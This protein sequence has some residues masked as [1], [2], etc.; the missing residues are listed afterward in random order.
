MNKKTFLEKLRKKLK[1]LKAD[2]IED[3]IEEYDGY[4][5]EKVLSGKTEEEAIKAFGD[6]DELVKEILC[7]YKINEDYEK[8]IKEKNALEDSIEDVVNFIKDFIKQISRK[9]KKDVI[10]FIIE[11]IALIFFIAIL[12]APVIIIEK[13]GCL[14]LE[15]LISPFGSVLAIIWKYMIEII[16]LILSIVGIVNFVKKRYFNE[17]EVSYPCNKENKKIKIKVGKEKQPSKD[18]KK[19][20]SFGKI[21]ITI[22]KVSLV[23]IVIPAVFSLLLSFSFLIVGIILLLQG[24]PYVGI[25]MCGLTYVSLNYIFLDISFRFIFNIKLNSKLLLRSIITT[26]V[27]FIIGIGLSFYEIINTTYVDG[28]PNEYKKIVKKKEE[29]YTEDTKLTC[30]SIY[31]TSCH[32]KIDDSMQDNI[33]ATITYYDFNKDYKFNDDLEYK[34]KENNEYSFKKGYDLIISDLRKRKFHDYSKLNDINLTIKLSSE[35]MQK[36]KERQDKEYSYDD[37]DENAYNKS[38]EFKDG[39][40]VYID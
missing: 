8:E 21:I 26:I 23:F 4:I 24:V 30:N 18:I 13:F 35:S 25:F 6:F 39:D 38:I 10:K 16:Y 2:E 17:E 27:L 37:D 1:I 32:Y 11:F 5:N 19:E 40:E 20:S 3:I 15:K 14:F 28:A 31:H 36:I 7:A 9:S 22:I 12:K 34:K 29:K 33:L